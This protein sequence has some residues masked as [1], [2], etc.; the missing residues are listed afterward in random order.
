MRPAPPV[1]RSP[2]KDFALIDQNVFLPVHGPF[3]FLCNCDACVFPH[4]AA[5]RQSIFSFVFPSC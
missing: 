4:S 3:S 1:T 5:G 2:D